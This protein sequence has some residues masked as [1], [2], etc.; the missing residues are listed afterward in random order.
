MNKSLQRRPAIIMK[1]D[2]VQFHQR[3]GRLPI[4]IVSDISSYKKFFVVCYSV[5]DFNV[6]N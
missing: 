5:L 6:A 3:H 2:I 1:T 4:E